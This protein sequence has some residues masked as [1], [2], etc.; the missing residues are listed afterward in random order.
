MCDEEGVKEWQLAREKSGRKPTFP[1]FETF[2]V[3]YLRFV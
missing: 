2:Q 1:T 3:E